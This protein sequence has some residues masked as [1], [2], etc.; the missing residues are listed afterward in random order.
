MQDQSEAN[1]E[2][3]K[4]IEINPDNSEQNKDEK[5]TPQL[6]QSKIRTYFSKID[7]LPMDTLTQDEKNDLLRTIL[8][9]WVDFKN[10]RKFKKLLSFRK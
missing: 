6:V 8:V 1:G 2:T 7:Y 5:S 4:R 9:I 3:D 10:K